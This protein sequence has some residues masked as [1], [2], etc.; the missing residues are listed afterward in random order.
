MKHT[1]MKKSNTIPFSYA[2]I[3]QYQLLPDIVVASDSAVIMCGVVKGGKTVAHVI[4]IIY[5][6]YIF[7]NSKF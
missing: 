1:K 4:K 2:S 5:Q 7:V 3:T 6:Y